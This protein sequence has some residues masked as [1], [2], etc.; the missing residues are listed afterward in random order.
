MPGGR[1]STHD[2]P[3]LFFTLNGPYI[4]SSSFFI[5]QLLCRFFP[6]SHT[7][8]P[9][10]KETGCQFQL[11]LRAMVFLASSR[12][13]QAL[14]NMLFMWWAMLS[15]DWYFYCC[16]EFISCRPCSCV[17]LMISSNPLL[18][19][20]GDIPVAAESIL[21]CANSTSGNSSS[22]FDCS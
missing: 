3:C 10:L 2:D 19:K 22:Q 6:F 12:L 5:G 11:A 21:L 8:S 20:K 7:R 13:F 14:F 18:A 9:M 17:K 15:A 1:S 4:L 16:L